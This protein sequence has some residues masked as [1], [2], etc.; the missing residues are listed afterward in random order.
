MSND[1]KID[2]LT[3]DKPIPNQKFVCL[4]FLSPESISNC[5][6][7]GLKVRGV[8]DTYEEASDR[9]KSLRDSDKYFHVF[10][11]EVGKWLPWDPEPDSKNVKDS[12]YAE[13]ELNKLMHAYMKNQ[14][15]AQKFE[16]ER[17]N[18][19]M[20]KSI[21]ENIEI[22]QKTKNEVQEELE[23]FRANNKDNQKEDNKMIEENLEKTLKTIDEEIEKL[24]KKSKEL[25]DNKKEVVSTIENSMISEDEIKKTEQELESAKEKYNSMVQNNI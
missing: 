2:Y 8:Y 5:K 18:N 15:D 17:K 6:I 25:I 19:L 16:E 13:T 22:R 3:E 1:Q 4:S 24:E 21:Q 23:K 10:V 12:E 11:G 9:A 20:E 7:R 14:K